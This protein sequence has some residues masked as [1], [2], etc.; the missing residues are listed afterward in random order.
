[1][2]FFKG[3]FARCVDKPTPT[4]LLPFLVLFML[5]VAFS[6]LSTSLFCNVVLS[7]WCDL[8]AWRWGVGGGCVGLQHSSK[9]LPYSSSYVVCFA[10][11][12]LV[13]FLLLVALFSSL[14]VIL[15]IGRLLLLMLIAFFFFLYWSCC[16]CFAFFLV[17]VLL[18]VTFFLFSCWSYCW[19]PF[20]S[21]VVFA[22][23]C[24][25]FSFILFLLLITFF[26]FSC[27]S[28]Y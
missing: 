25:F 5:L 15:V 2:V 20:S 23:G 28:C 7:F 24:L 19:S 1:M 8:G 26:L 4:C 6:F 18:L 3:S 11:C 27:S 13:L 10:G 14:C 9:F 21:C 17:L 12:S 22:I 16:C